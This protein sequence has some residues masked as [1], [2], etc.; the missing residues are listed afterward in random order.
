MNPKKPYSPPKIYEVELNQN[1]AILTV[2]KSGQ[3]AQLS[4]GGS[5]AQRCNTGCRRYGRATGDSG[6]RPS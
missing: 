4:D 3:G 2:C 1:Q 6:Q 5:R